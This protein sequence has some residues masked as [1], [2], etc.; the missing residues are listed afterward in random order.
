MLGRYTLAN[1]VKVTLSAGISAVASSIT[2]NAATGLFNDPPDP[3]GDMA[4][5]GLSIATIQDAA[6]PPNNTEI[7]TYTGVTD[8]GDG[9]LTL[10][11]VQRAIEGSTA[12]PWSTDDVLFQAATAGQ[13]SDPLLFA[14]RTVPDALNVSAGSVV[15]TK[16]SLTVRPNTPPGQDVGRLMLAGGGA[17]NKERGAYLSLNGANFSNFIGPGGDATLST[18][19]D[20]EI[21]AN[22]GRATIIGTNSISIETLGTFDLYAG[23]AANLGTVNVDIL[24]AKYRIYI[25]D[26]P[27]LGIRKTGWSAS[28]G[29]AARSAYATYSAPT[30][31]ATYN[32]TVQGQ[33]NTALTHIEVL[34]QQVKALKDDLIA[35]G[36]IGLT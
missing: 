17:A 11:D 15:F 14:D 4:S 12:R 34:S 3:T 7:I 27:V 28:T 18:T 23:I 16:N 33:L 2:V 36:L 8:N 13:F 10:T 9:T 22:A 35:H 26:T 19:G 21:S 25:N 29:T 24:Y 32:A 20:I 1:N 30:V 6:I 31:G 5:N